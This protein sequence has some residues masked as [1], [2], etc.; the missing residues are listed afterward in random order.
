VSFTLANILTGLKNTLLV[1]GA[2]FLIGCALGFPLALARQYGHPLLRYLIWVLV[3][4][5][6]GIP[7]ILWLFLL[8][9]TLAQGAVTM[10]AMT[11]SIIAIAII[12]SAHMSENYRTGFKAVS[13]GQWESSRALGM[14]EPTLLYWVVV[15]QVM[16]VSVPPA[17][18]LAIGLLKESAIVSVIG[19]H[20][21]TYFA[22][23]EVQRNLNG[24][25]VYASIALIYIALSLV[26]AYAGSRIEASLRRRALG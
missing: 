23:T 4:I 5:V 6:R 16:R 22:F 25:Q 24:L 9:Y 1:T 8:Y 15:P 7:T 21:I 3:D 11:A 17:I 14:S 19:V 26:V 12:A 18:T 2:G 10:G 13:K 20:D